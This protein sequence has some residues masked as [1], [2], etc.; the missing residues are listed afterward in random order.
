MRLALVFSQ[1]LA[2]T[3]TRL[4]SGA[5]EAGHPLSPPFASPACGPPSSHVTGVAC[6]TCLATCCQRWGMLRVVH[7]GEAGETYLCCCRTP[8]PVSLHHLTTFLGSDWSFIM[9]RAFFLS[10]GAYLSFFLLPF[11]LFHCGITL[12]SWSYFILKKQKAFLPEHSTC[13]SV[14]LKTVT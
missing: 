5:F 4:S 14:A 10:S 13:T 1:R 3:P 6:R 2:P 8:G 12:L 11:T 7:V 9:S